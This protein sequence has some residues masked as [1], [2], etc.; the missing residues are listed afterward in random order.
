[1]SRKTENAAT[2][3]A[4]MDHAPAKA[5]RPAKYAL[6][7]GGAGFI[8]SHIAERLLREGYQVRI[9]DDFS[10]G[11]E[12]NLGFAYGN[13]RLRVIRG[14]IRDPIACAIACDGVEVIF[15][16]AALHS[17]P[18]SMNTPHE[19]NSVNIDGTL[20][21]LEA[22]RDAG[23]KRFVFASSSSIYGDTDTFP[24][25]EDQYPLLISPY[26]LSKLAGEYYCRIFSE[27][28][29]MET[30]CLRY[31][32]VFGPRQSLDDEYAV[33]VPKFIN[34]IL[35]AE[36]PPIFGNG[37]QS[38]DFTFVGNVVEANM[39]A[40]T[41]KGIRH[42]VVNVANG[43]ATTVLQ[44]LDELNRIMGTTVPPT[45]LPE[46]AGDVFKT[47]AD[48]TRLR[49]VFGYEAKA[50]FEQGLRETVDYFLGER[51]AERELRRAAAGAG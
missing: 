46:R 37:K 35:D 16:E 51:R 15:H 25:S 2:E 10:N 44:L 42:E 21:L 7:T 47:H 5:A 40:A 32:N 1:M 39:L 22:A 36:R 41:A 30:V 38:R 17:V 12:E 48:I 31:F 27:F 20:T 23:I 3:R 8:G 13:P 26:A 45:F 4:E 28:H 19:F 29:G 49:N 14:D 6:V 33:V 11:R 24:E 34:S 9:L 50:D 18:R 43:C